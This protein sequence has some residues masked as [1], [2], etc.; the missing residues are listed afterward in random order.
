MSTGGKWNRKS[1][2]RILLWCIA[3]SVPSLLTIAIP[4]C[5]KET[6]Y[7]RPRCDIN[8]KLIG[9][10][11][12]IYAHDY[13][14]WFPVGPAGTDSSYA[15]G[16]LSY[17]LGGESSYVQDASTYLCPRSDTSIGDW[18]QGK[19]RYTRSAA[20]G[21]L[22]PSSTSYEYVPRLRN[23]SPVDFMLAFDD[24]PRVH[25][26]PHYRCRPDP[27]VRNV[28]FVDGH[29]EWKLEDEFQEHTSWQREMTKR[30]QEGVDLTPFEEWRES[31]E[32][33][34]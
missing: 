1:D 29:V 5:G 21:G 34:K 22:R 20:D 15:L 19:S 7:Y 16:I 3:L 31:G 23:D 30:L 18:R 26:R 11:M 25:R 33:T 4:G 14:G 2:W 12:H 13:D 27:A 10:A 17:D 9:L 6:V 8:L 28:L 24:A 32:A